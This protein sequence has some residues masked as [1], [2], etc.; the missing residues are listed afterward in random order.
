[1]PAA[2]TAGVRGPPTAGADV[3]TGGKAGAAAGQP[4]PDVGQQLDTK[5]GIDGAAA[6][7]QAAAALTA[8]P[9]VTQAACSRAEVQGAATQTGAAPLV[10]APQEAA[11]HAAALQEECTAQRSAAQ[12]GTKPRAAAPQG[13]ASQA[14]ASH[15]AATQAV[16]GV[17][18]GAASASQEAALSGP[19]VSLPAP[20]PGS[21]SG[22]GVLPPDAVLRL[23]DYVGTRVGVGVGVGEWGLGHRCGGGVE[24]VGEW[25]LGHSCG[26]GVEGVGEGIGSWDTVVEVGVAVCTFYKRYLES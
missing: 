20:A 23:E 15:A 21:D 9:W 6:A 17:A 19:T 13:A 22:V 8:A 1:M 3:S 12:T 16:R 4:S 14:A 7:L 18:Q 25:G 24:G 5:G 11:A 26:G 10:V 2:K